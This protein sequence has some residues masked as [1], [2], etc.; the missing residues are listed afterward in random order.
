MAKVR[1]VYRC[2]DCGTATPKWAGRC[3]TCEAWNSLVE[4]AETRDSPSAALS[5]SFYF[6]SPSALA[7]RVGDVDASFAQPHPTGID[8][9]DRVLG[10]GL[11]PGSVTLLGGEPGIG[12][13]TLLLQLLAKWPQR[14]LYVSAEE[15]A[16]QV[17]LRAERLAARKREGF[18]TR[19]AREERERKRRESPIRKGS[20]PAGASAR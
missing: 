13:S 12:K 4:E 3:T 6:T 20:K 16:Q 19:R 2:T 5:Q 1:L 17:R 11:V 15:S 8:E 10:G 9:L 7:T 18:F 14:T